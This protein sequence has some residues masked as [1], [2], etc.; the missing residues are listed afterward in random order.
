MRFVRD[1]TALQTTYAF[2]YWGSE[3]TAPAIVTYR[4]YTAPNLP[5]PDDLYY[6]SQSTRE[7]SA[8][9]KERFRA[10]LDQFEN[11]TGLIFVEVPDKANVNIV[12]VVGSSWGGWSGY[13]GYGTSLDLALDETGP[14]IMLHEIGHAVGLKH[15]FEGD[16][17]LA[18]DLDRSSN[19]IMSYSGS[20]PVLGRFD[21]D[22]LRD[23]YGLPVD[24]SGWEFSYDPEGLGSTVIWNSQWLG[25]LLVRGGAGNDHIAAA[26]GYS[27]HLNGQGGN[28]D[29][30]GE[31]F[32]DLLEG[33]AGHDTL[34]GVDDDDTLY[35]GSGNDVLTGAGG[36]DVVYGG[37]GDD[38]LW[39]G[40]DDDLLGGSVGN[41]SLWGGA[42]DDAMWG[43][44]G[45][46]TLIG[47]A[48]SDTLGGSL[49]NDSLSGGAGWDEL[50]GAEGQDTLEGGEGDDRLGGGLDGD[51]VSGGGGDDAV[52]GGLGDDVL[53]GDAG[54]DTL[55]GAG[56]DDTLDGG[57]GIDELYVGAGAD[58]VVVS[59]GIDRVYYFSALEDRIDLSG[60]AWATDYESLRRTD[61]AAS[62]ADAVIGGDRGAG[63]ILQGVDVLDLT[64]DNFIF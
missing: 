32:A 41:D 12:G 8:A 7:L 39:G 53:S 13:P 10:A 5:S 20:S 22:A 58:V 21:I 35:G 62:G 30:L 4:F 28:D 2:G 44:S 37:V 6:P 64:A 47:G 11:A 36:R 42:G 49:G 17:Q 14:K 25:T 34:N 59:G 40:D 52:F 51:S 15:P 9:E 19:T 18:S 63:L 1:W 43:G 55:F 61:L 29:L 60:V 33:G 57:Y 50:W 23:Q 48:G 27:A 16:I 54:S 45:D 3:V 31:Q 56:G 24:H 46:D 38:I 26:E